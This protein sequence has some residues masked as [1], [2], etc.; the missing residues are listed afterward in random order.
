MSYQNYIGIKPMVPMKTIKG[1]SFLAFQGRLI[2]V[3]G[4]VGSG[5][6]RYYVLLL[7]RLI[8][9]TCKTTADYHQEKE[10][11]FRKE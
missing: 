6:V 10:L 7:K 4:A 9:I 11:S 5:K 1:S 2:G 3:V 8:Y